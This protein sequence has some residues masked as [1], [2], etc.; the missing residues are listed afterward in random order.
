MT[1]SGRVARALARRPWPQ[2]LM[3]IYRSRSELDLTTADLSRELD[4][5]KADI[6]INTAA[7]TDVDGAES[8][9]AAA[10][11]ANVEA[12]ARLADATRRRGVFLLHLSTDYVFGHGEGPWREDSPSEPLGVYGESKRAGELE[13]LARDPEAL[14]VRTA[15]LFDGVSSNFLTAM[16][17]LRGRATLDVVSDQRGSPTF[18]DDLADGLLALSAQTA[19]RRGGLLHFANAGEGATRFQMADA[20]FQSAQAFGVGAPQ[21][22]PLLSRDWPSAALRPADS[23]LSIA[24]WREWGLPAPRNWKSAVTAAVEQARFDDG[25]AE[26]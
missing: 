1:G 19:G 5:I 6:V 8:R 23:R 15:W 7:W 26:E 13:V 10:W 9:R 21:L 20:I 24:R 4:E 12:P 18:T 14:V 11:A 17:N 22:R 16:M 2:G 25:R 3:P